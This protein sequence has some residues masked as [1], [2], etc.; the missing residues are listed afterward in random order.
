[1]TDSWLRSHSH[2]QLLDEHTAIPPFKQEKLV[3]GPLYWG[4]NR[5]ALDPKEGNQHWDRIGS[6]AGGM[7]E[8]R[9]SGS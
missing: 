4:A 3:L 5:S 1:M 2:D 7:N 8:D 9:C 6:D